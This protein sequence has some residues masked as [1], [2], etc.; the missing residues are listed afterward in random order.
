MLTGING[1]ELLEFI[2]GVF[3]V[4]SW[5]MSRGSRA[6]HLEEQLVEKFK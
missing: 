5:K 1:L 6:A 3:D 4:S 2:A